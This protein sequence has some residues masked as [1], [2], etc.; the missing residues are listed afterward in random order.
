M[1]ALT[2]CPGLTHPLHPIAGFE[3][4]T[5]ST[6]VKTLTVPQDAVMALVNVQGADV[7][8][9][10]DGTDPNHDTGMLAKQDTTFAVCGGAMGTIKFIWDDITAAI[11]VS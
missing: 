1:S 11:N 7:Y 9:R 4:I 2:D 5:V 6:L 10:D 3:Q 8:W